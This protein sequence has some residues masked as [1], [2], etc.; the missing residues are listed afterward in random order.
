V[1]LGVHGEVDLG[2][3]GCVGRL[4]S[5]RR[6]QSGLEWLHACM[7]GGCAFIRF[8]EEDFA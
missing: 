1:V 2:C 5:R 7:A 8:R 6:W 4:S 3:V